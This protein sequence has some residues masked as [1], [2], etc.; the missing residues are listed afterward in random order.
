MRA[1]QF[2]LHFC[3]PPGLCSL[4]C[5]WRCLSASILCDMFVDETML[6]TYTLHTPTFSHPPFAEAP[7]CLSTGTRCDRHFS[8]HSF[9]DEKLSGT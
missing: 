5:S 3:R 1:L 7:P 9:Y 8:D 2:P 4:S 6:V